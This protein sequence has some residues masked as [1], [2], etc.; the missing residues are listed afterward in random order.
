MGKASVY[1][2]YKNF[3][4]MCF[5]NPGY[6]LYY[7]RYSPIV[8]KKCGHVTAFFLIRTY[9]FFSGENILYELKDIS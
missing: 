6:T 1:A 5:E 7:T 9:R 4:V 3:L 2:V 8:K